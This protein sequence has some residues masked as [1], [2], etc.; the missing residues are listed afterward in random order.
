[1]L[2]WLCCLTTEILNNSLRGIPLSP[3]YFIFKFYTVF[4]KQYVIT[5]LFNEIYFGLNHNICSVTM[6][7]VITI[8]YPNRFIVS[9][10][11]KTA[12]LCSVTS[13]ALVDSTELVSNAKCDSSGSNVSKTRRSL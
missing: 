13:C 7:S 1:M 8:K 5:V 2:Y 11:I 4:A 6:I 12:V 10:I 9:S 3:V